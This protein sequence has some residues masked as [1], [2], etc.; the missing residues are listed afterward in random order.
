MARGA[1]WQLIVVMVTVGVSYGKSSFKIHFGKLIV[2]I[3]EFE[4][5]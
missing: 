4:Y 2:K 1:P 5:F 3:E